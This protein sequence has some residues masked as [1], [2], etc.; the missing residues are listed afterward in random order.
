MN[1]NVVPEEVKGW[2]WGA[3]MYSILWGFGNK[4][5]LP[6]LMLIPVFNIFWMFVVG[7][8][9]NEWAWKNG[10]YTDVAT[11]KAV[12]ATWNRAGFVMFMI[13]VVSVLFTVGLIVFG[14]LAAWGLGK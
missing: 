2:N 3:F 1:N 5:Y 4:S 13:V 11:F 7:I 6:L 14:G 12:Q 8:K 10:D 9:G